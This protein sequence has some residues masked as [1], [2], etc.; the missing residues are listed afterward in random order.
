MRKLLLTVAAGVLSVSMFAQTVAQKHDREVMLAKFKNA[1]AVPYA[2]KSNMDL[3]GAP[4]NTSVY[5]K[6]GS[7]TG[8]AIGS[9]GYPLQSNS[10]AADRVIAYADGSI[11]AVWTGSTVADGAWADRGMF[12][13]HNDGGS[14]GPAPTARVET[15]RSGFGSIVS[16]ME[17]EIVV[18]HDCCNSFIR[19]FCCWC[20]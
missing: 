13:N 7:R 20:Y 15:V 10:A 5:Y 11:S 12:Y 17:H 9:T 2:P 8:E 4:L 3:S 1:Q 16:V 6:S 18:S 19:E 14:W